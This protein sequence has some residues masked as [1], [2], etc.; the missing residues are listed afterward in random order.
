M[1]TTLEKIGKP[2]KPRKFELSPLKP[3]KTS[4]KKVTLEKDFQKPK[5]LENR[6]GPSKNSFFKRLIKM[7]SYILLFFIIIIIIVFVKSTLLNF[8]QI[9]FISETEIVLY[10]LRYINYPKFVTVRLS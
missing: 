5:T 7:I 8:T 2:R 10:Y 4:K 6:H 1:A 3:S 9:T